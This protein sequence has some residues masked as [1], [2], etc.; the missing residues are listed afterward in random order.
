VKVIAAI[1]ALL[2]LVSLCGNPVAPPPGTVTGSVFYDANRNGIRDS[3]DSPLKNTEVVV[4]GADGVQRIAETDGSGAFAVADAPVGND[5]VSLLA[6][7]GYIW[8]ITTGVAVASVRV[9]SDKTVAAGEFGSASRSAYRTG[10]VLVTGIVFDDQDSDGVVDRNECAL[11]DDS[12]FISVTSG[13]RAVLVDRDGSFEIRGAGDVALVR[14]EFAGA[15]TPQPRFVPTTQLEGQSSCLASTRPVQRYGTGIYEAIIGFTDHSPFRTG[16]VAGII[17]SDRDEDGVHDADEPGVPNVRLRISARNPGCTSKIVP[18]N[19]VTDA[20]G[21]F[22]VGNLAPGEYD[23]ATGFSYYSEPIVQIV[24]S[25]V[26]TV[27]EGSRVEWNLAVAEVPPSR[28]VVQAF[29]DV[30]GDGLRDDS[31]LPV[32][33]LL[34][35]GST[36]DMD[37]GFVPPPDSAFPGGPY[38]PFCASTDDAGSVTIGPLGTGSYYVGYSSYYPRTAIR[39]PVEPE[40]VD[41]ATGETVTIAFAIDVLTPEE[42]VILPG[43]GTA[44]GLA[45]CYSEPDWVQPSFESGITGEI[46]TRWGMS[47]D[48]AARIYGHGIYAVASR[49]ASMWGDVSGKRWQDFG[50]GSD[51]SFLYVLL[52][53]ELIDAARSADGSLVQ[54]RLARRDSGLYAVMLAGSYTDESVYKLFVDEAYNPIVRCSPYVGCEWNDGSELQPVF[55]GVS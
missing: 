46:L 15:G 51:P 52:N 29:D 10:E 26:V 42:Q 36:R 20:N 24:S 35:C 55:G 23:A 47:Y 45:E 16:T 11:P 44:L 31:E 13:E 34:F 33:G 53:Y 37:G 3:C 48:V 40:R 22:L 12:G 41:V 30:N 7:E 1:P 32:P 38:P 17:F 19:L 25:A 9:E 5:Q 4:T 2:V 21:R 39:L 14:A 18:M 6:D 43:A 27:T 8:P 50:C 28:I 54:V 49:E